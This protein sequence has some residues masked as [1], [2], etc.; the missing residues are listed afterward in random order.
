[1]SAAPAS[2]VMSIGLSTLLRIKATLDGAKINNLIT[3][4]KGARR[5]L[6]NAK[7][8]QRELS[9]SSFAEK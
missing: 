2:T 4:W 3:F 7:R 1:M 9:A 6:T 8:R 5:G